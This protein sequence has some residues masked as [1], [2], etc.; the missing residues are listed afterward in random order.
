MQSF[1]VLSPALES[2]EERIRMPRNKPH[3]FHRMLVKIFFTILFKKRKRR[4]NNIKVK[5]SE[6]FFLRKKKRFENEHKTW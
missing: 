1:F 5:R 6:K 2:R 4:K 3:F